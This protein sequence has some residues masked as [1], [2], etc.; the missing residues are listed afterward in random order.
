ME[1]LKKRCF[2]TRIY[3]VINNEKNE[4]NKKIEF[5]CID[6]H[7]NRYNNIIISIYKIPS[8]SKDDNTFITS[9]CECELE[10]IKF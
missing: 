9:S 8:D 1:I 5:K 6:T 4:E 7:T 10:T 2:V 3:K